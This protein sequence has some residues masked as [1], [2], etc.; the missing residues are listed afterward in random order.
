MS[1]QNMYDHMLK[2][3]REYNGAYF[4]A[5]KILDEDTSLRE[6]PVDS[7]C[8]RDCKKVVDAGMALMEA[9]DPGAYDE[10][11]KAI[12]SAVEIYWRG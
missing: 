10:I 2:R 9:S 8:G 7:V 11:A 1:K 12:F 4:D 3:F 5:K 6:L